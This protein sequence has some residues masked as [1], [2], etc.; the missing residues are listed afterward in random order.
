MGE[1]ERERQ[2]DQPL[3]KRSHDSVAPATPKC[4][5]LGL[6]CIMTACAKFDHRGSHPMAIGDTMLHV[7]ENYLKLLPLSIPY[8]SQF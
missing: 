3:G 1:R 4:R 6:G 5:M 8:V 7:T 2:R